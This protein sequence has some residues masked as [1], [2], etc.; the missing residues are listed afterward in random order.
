MKVQ[1]NDEITVQVGIANPI[2]RV[3]TVVRVEREE[4]TDFVDYVCQD[5]HS[6]WCDPRQIVWNYG[7]NV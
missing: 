5:G 6:F 4:E 7:P 2:Y 1:V 3:G